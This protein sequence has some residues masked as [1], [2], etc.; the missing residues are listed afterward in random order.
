MYFV[1]DMKAG[2]VID[3][4]CIRS[5]RPGFGLAPKYYEELMGKTVQY[6]I[7]ANSATSMDAIN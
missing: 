1:K 4:S 2:D 6:N 3:E 5:V 7:T